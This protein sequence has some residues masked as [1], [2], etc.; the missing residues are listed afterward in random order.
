MPD[1]GP[2]PEFM[3]VVIMSIVGLFCRYPT[4]RDVILYYGE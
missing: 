1:H 4:A 2:Q 3:A